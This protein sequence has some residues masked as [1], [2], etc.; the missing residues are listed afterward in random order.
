MKA[1][2]C[3]VH[4][5]RIRGEGADRNDRDSTTFVTIKIGFR[6]GSREKVV[7]ARFAEIKK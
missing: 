5:D 7:V 3:W 4:E 1:P 2:I 6:Q